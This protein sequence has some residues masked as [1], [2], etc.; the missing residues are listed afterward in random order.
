MKRFIAFL[1]SFLIVFCMAGCATNEPEVLDEETIKNG[2]SFGDYQYPVM[3]LTV[4]GLSDD[5]NAE[6]ALSATREVF[7]DVAGIEDGWGNVID[8]TENYVITNTT[9]AD[10]TTTLCYPYV[11]DLCLSEYD[12]LPRMVVSGEGGLIGETNAPEEWTITVNQHDVWANM[13]PYE[14]EIFSYGDFCKW[15]TENE[16]ELLEE[17][18]WTELKSMV[19]TEYT[20]TLLEDP[21]A[22][23]TKAVEQGHIGNVHWNAYYTNPDNVAVI[24][25]GLSSYGGSE[26]AGKPVQFI[27]SSRDVC[28]GSAMR[29]VALGGDVELEHF[30]LEYIEDIKA[31]EVDCKT[32]VEIR[33]IPLETWLE[34]NIDVIYQKAQD[35][36]GPLE[37]IVTKE[38][39]TACIWYMISDYMEYSAREDFVDL[40]DVE[41]LGGY[42]CTQNWLQYLYQQVT[43]PAGSSLEVT[44]EQH[45]H[46]SKNMN[47]GQRKAND[48][49]SWFG[50][51][52]A[53]SLGSD[54]DFT[55]QTAQ[56]QLED[57]IV[58]MADNFIPDEAGEIVLQEDL[59]YFYYLTRLSMSRE[60]RVPP[61]AAAKPVIYLYPEEEMDVSVTLAIEGELTSTWPKYNEAKGWQVTARPDG[62]IIDQDGYEYSYLFW[63]AELFQE[64]DFSEGFVVSGEDSAEFLREKL[65]Y[66]GLTPEEYNEFI[67][68]WAP[69]LEENPYNLISF[70]WENYQEAA[71]LQIT[72][73]PDN[74]LRVYMAYQPLEKPIE[75]PEQELPIL[76]REGFTVVEWGGCLLK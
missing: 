34:E 28:K 62:T 41:S 7:V 40:L 70:Q 61:G 35:F 72:P 9:T 53:T 75:L 48:S 21:D 15:I 24:V 56:F 68:Y 31:N 50:L 25:D 26:E 20:F 58:V 69:V 8:I 5:L 36:W 14:D 44:V 43:I 30:A 27:S 76:E 52:V 33:T 2:L 29:L 59:H 66:I 10:V 55:K 18:D 74:I 45:K 42:T 1:L 13:Y 73:S 60:S 3:P 71:K 12:T 46:N 38:K 65:S 22:E 51:E 17:P 57:S 4:T 49:G 64:L 54:L 23:K 11:A 39:L 67:V 37:E 19:V 32:D 6:P 16:G 63:E 47:Y